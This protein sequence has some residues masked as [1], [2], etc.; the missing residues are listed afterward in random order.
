M[1]ACGRH[2]GA[3]SVFLTLILLPTVVFGGLVTD[4]VRVYQA[5]GLISEAGEL[6]MNAGLSYYDGALKNAYGLLALEKMPEDLDI[7]Q[8]FVNTLR[9]SGLEGAKDVKSMMDLQVE[10]GSFQ[11]YGVDGSK[12]YETEAEKMQIL[13]YMKYRAPVCI[14]EQLL[15]K[16]GQIKNSKK[17]VEV[18][19][20][21][22]DFSD[23]LDDLQ[24]ACEKAKE[25][26]DS[27]CDL[28]EE[29]PALTRQTLE[30]EFV[31]LQS[32]LREAAT[33]IFVLDVIDHDT[34]ADH[35]DDF[36]ASMEN[37]NSAAQYLP[38][39]S[40]LPFMSGADFAAALADYMSC[41]SSM[42]G[43]LEKIAP[44]NDIGAA[45]ANRIS[46]VD[47]DEQEQIENIYSEC[48]ELNARFSAFYFVL[49]D[50]AEE[51][52]KAAWEHLPWWVERLGFVMEQIDKASQC[53]DDLNQKLAIA[54][55]KHK[56]WTDKV[57]ELPDGGGEFKSTMTSEADETKDLLDEQ[58]LL[59]LKQKLAD[60][61]ALWAQMRGELLA[62]SFC[63][64]SLGREYDYN[65]YPAARQAVRNWH[66][67]NTRYNLLREA[68]DAA[69]DFVGDGSHIDTYY[70]G[71]L[72]A[73][74]PP[75]VRDDEFYKKLQEICREKRPKDEKYHNYKEDTNN[76]LKKLG[77]SVT[78]DGI[79]GL[80]DIDW[81]EKPLP[82]TVLSQS[83]A[84]AESD[85]DD[86]NDINCEK[87]NERKK[88]VKN[89]RKSIDSVGK[90]LTTLSE[91][92]EEAIEN[93][94]LT[95]YGIEMFSYYTVDKEQTEY[96]GEVTQR[97]EVKSLSGDDLTKH[98]LYRSEVE[99]MLW[100]QKNVQENVKN[101]RL[102]LYGVRL[103]F[104]M[105]YAFSDSQVRL[106]SETMAAALSCGV[107]FL[108][109][110]FKAVIKVGIAIA[111]TALDVTDLMAGKHVGL[112]KDK[113]TRQVEV[114]GFLTRTNLAGK[115]PITMNYREYLTLFLLIKTFGSLE[116][117][118]L[119][120]IADCIQL[121][122]ELD[123]T[124]S[125]TMLAVC[126][127]V[128]VR[129]AFMKK[130]SALPDG[131]GGGAVSGEYT[132]TFKSALGY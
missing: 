22:L 30:A 15:E 81:D 24:E 101:T 38:L 99:Y 73:N 118:T 66:L 115:K 47:E 89:A 106:M 92:T 85:Y 55:E 42:A 95:A 40:E 107:A 37:F 96:D 3:I 45:V 112:L 49:Q 108:I 78:G 128:N 64:Q 111:E 82:S 67:T 48:I 79:N 28:L 72:P 93:L 116:A 126:A 41:A 16:L 125:Y 35:E 6:A 71:Q 97:A 104:N 57:G 124:Q 12:I 8:Y 17:Q 80:A 50:K 77:T 123:I 122:T 43:I 103:V 2:R 51:K 21:Q 105:I 5:K 120:R 46:M 90:F 83:G 59:A 23:S 34:T 88:A 29:E 53:L 33:W 19:D 69:I 65:C 76:W 63:Q 13:E 32:E 58:K 84:D 74:M 130:V 131:G 129:T 117:K 14:G 9:A 20:A 62:T 56:T 52:L 114:P 127:K 61:R 10:G 86:Q 27:Y 121:N 68:S 26:L 60:S 54:Q 113:Y 132:V 36:I 18:I 70:R 11:V 100:G 31:Y 25:A 109:P 102:L 44:S 39:E 98:K 75:S 4:A 91:L 119:A 87:K 1:R 7:E 110:I 94:Y